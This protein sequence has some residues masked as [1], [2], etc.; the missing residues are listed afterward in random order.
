MVWAALLM[1][2][3]NYHSHCE[4]VLVLSTVLIARPVFPIPFVSSIEPLLKMINSFITIKPV[5]TVTIA[6]SFHTWKWFRFLT[7]GGHEVLSCVEADGAVH[8]KYFGHRNMFW[9]QV[10]FRKVN[11]G[12][13]QARWGPQ[14]VSSHFLSPQHDNPSAIQIDR[15]QNIG[16]CV[17]LSDSE[18]K[19]SRCVH[20]KQEFLGTTHGKF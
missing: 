5:S 6:E 3:T 12:H 8:T 20:D 4:S 16:Q 2:S 19:G 7:K 9:V 14:P 15:V 13:A 11:M 1:L 17:R 18:K 10:F